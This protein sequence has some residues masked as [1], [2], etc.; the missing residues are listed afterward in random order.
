MVEDAEHGMGRAPGPGAVRPEPSAGR[1][2]PG[3]GRGRPRWSQ[4]GR[5]W[6]RRLGGPASS[7]NL[8]PL[9]PTGLEAGSPGCSGP[10][11]LPRAGGSGH[12]STAGRR[13]IRGR[14]GWPSPAASTIIPYVRAPG[15]LPPG[16]PVSRPPPAASPVAVPGASTP[17][18]RPPHRPRWHRPSL[19]SPGVDGAGDPAASAPED[20][21]L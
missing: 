6:H 7:T 14:P 2:R 4:P 19:P 12:G 3:A 21:Q 1:S 8:N 16:A 9:L 10:V 5:R 13:R 20:G 18:P 11:T 15:G 17:P